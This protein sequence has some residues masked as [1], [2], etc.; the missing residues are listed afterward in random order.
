MNTDVNPASSP[1]QAGSGSGER[2]LK[3]I[4]AAGL[5]ALFWVIGNLI[6]SFALFLRGFDIPLPTPSRVL[7][8]YGSVTIPLFGVL[9]AC[10]W[11]LSDVYFRGR[12]LQWFLFAFYALVIF[13]IVLE[14]VPAFNLNII[15][16]NS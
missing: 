4:I 2:S 16:V 3:W 12:W 9:A 14:V 6:G 1:A 10:A 8:D 11:V 13:G 15:N 7:I 5:V